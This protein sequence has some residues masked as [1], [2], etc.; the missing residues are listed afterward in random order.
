MTVIEY[1]KSVFWRVLYFISPR[2]SAEYGYTRLSGG[3]VMDWDDPKDLREKII[4]LQFNS[5]T[6]LWTLCADKYRV[7]EYVLEKGCGDI[8]NE[9][10]GVWNNAKDIDYS[11]LPDQFVLKTNNSCGQMIFVKD[12]TK[13][14][15]SSLNKQLNHWLK[16]KYGYKGAQKHYLRIEPKIIAEKLLINTVEPDKSLVDYKIWCFN[17]KP[18]MIWVAF[19]RTKD[20]YEYSAFDLEWNNI[21]EIVLDTNSAHYSGRDFPRPKSFSRMLECAKALSEPFKEVRAD[22]YDIDGRAVFGELTFTAGNVY[23][24]KDYYLRLGEKI[25]LLD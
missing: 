25:S 21:S 12:K 24:T 14:N 15:F 1:I 20:S 23:F 9:L 16:I 7:R 5:D 8:L 18:E 22:F 2:L 13:C 10:Y 6:S 3:E 4:W 11:K 17:G 19:N